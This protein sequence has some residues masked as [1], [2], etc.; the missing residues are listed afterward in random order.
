M[1]ERNI[2]SYILERQGQIQGDP[3]KGRLNQTQTRTWEIRLSEQDFKTWVQSSNCNSLYFDGASKSN[4]GQAGAGGLIV[5]E[6]G[7]TIFSYEWSLGKRTNNSAEALALYQGLLQL[8]NLG[9]RRAMIFGDSSI[10]I[11]LMVQ[12]QS[13]PNTNL[14]QVIHR[15]KLLLQ[16]FEDIQFYHILR[17]LNKEV[18][19]RVNSACGRPMGI[20]RCN[21]VDSHQLIP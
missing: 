4:P 1:E 15:N 7:D 12:N 11:H 16:S 5:D 17:N 21:A 10:I 19:N 2:I 6:I 8:K 9:I 18:D 13:S 14:Q 20:L 3:I